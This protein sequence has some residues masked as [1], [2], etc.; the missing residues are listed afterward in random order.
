MFSF[1]QKLFS[2]FRATLF[3]SGR[4]P[5]KDFWFFLIV[6]VLL[7]F[8][9]LGA[10]VSYYR[11]NEPTGFLIQLQALLGGR[12]PFVPLFLLIFTPPLIAVTIR[13][14]HDY[15]RTGWWSLL[16][17]LPVLG[18]IPLGIML[19]RKGQDGF[20][21]FGADPLALSSLLKSDKVTNTSPVFVDKSDPSYAPAE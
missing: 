5:R 18:W 14:L 10:D 20:N 2:M 3:F 21:R 16:G 17:L 13:R 6:F 1:Y 7:F 15:G 9:S 11:H 4:S 19:G 12:E 8:A